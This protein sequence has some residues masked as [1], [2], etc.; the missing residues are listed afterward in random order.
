MRDTRVVLDRLQEI[1]NQLQYAPYD[2]LVPEAV[3]QLKDERVSLVK[4]LY[5]QF[6]TSD[7]KEMLKLRRTALGMEPKALGQL[8]AEKALQE[9]EDSVSRG[10]W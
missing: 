6:V 7:N 9:G 4:N 5:D 10:A 2:G 8:A 1:E 3:Q